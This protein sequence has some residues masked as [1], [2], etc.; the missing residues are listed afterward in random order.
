VTWR[1]P[2]TGALLAR[3][4]ELPAGLAVVPGDGGAVYYPTVFR[5]LH[6]LRVQPRP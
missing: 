5:G 3:S 6:E 1:H 4:G 2:D